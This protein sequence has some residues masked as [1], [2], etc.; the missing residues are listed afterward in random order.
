[1][2]LYCHRGWMLTKNYKNKDWAAMMRNHF[3][4]RFVDS[5]LEE[6]VINLFNNNNDIA[7]AYYRFDRSALIKV[8]CQSPITFKLRMMHVVFLINRMSNIS[9]EITAK[10][11]TTMKEI[12]DKVIDLKQ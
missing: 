12:L 6:W 5:S 2:E 8:L 9:D 3:C 10:E 7:K 1:M 11:K 4:L